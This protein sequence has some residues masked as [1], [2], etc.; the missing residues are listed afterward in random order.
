MGVYSTM[1]V[2]GRVNLVNPVGV[3]QPGPLAVCQKF[4][5]DVIWHV[6][7]VSWR[8]VEQAPI[9]PIFV[10]GFFGSFV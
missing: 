9:L 4:V 2:P 3:F 1:P 10:K 5:M 6:P 7:V 8:A